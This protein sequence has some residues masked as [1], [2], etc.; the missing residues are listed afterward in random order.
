MYNLPKPV[1]DSLMTFVLPRLFKNSYTYDY[2]THTMESAEETVDIP[3]SVRRNEAVVGLPSSSIALMPRLNI[4]PA[5]GATCT[6]HYLRQGTV[7]II[8]QH[9]DLHS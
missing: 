9:V 3:P 8:M 7:N 5:Y 4:S 1:Q 2:A 6:R